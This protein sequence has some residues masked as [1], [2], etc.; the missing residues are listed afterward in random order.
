M[1][2][3]QAYRSALS[4][5]ALVIIGE[6]FLG[7]TFTI[8][9]FCVALDLFDLKYKSYAN[10]LLHMHSLII[11]LR[12]SHTARHKH[13]RTHEHTR[14]HTYTHTNINKKHKQTN[15]QTHTHT[16]KSCIAV[17]SAI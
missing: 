9:L 11:P 14:T 10:S 12:D 17:M 15:K 3:L 6:C 16:G 1:L 2:S 7:V 13:A 8:C 4:D 5:N